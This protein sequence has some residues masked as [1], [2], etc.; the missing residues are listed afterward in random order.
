MKSKTT[1]RDPRRPLPLQ[2]RVKALIA[3][4]TASVALL[5]AGTA[6]AF[7]VE[8]YVPS[9]CFL[10]TS[11]GTMWFAHGAEINVVGS[12]GK[13]RRYRCNDG[14]WEPVKASTTPTRTSVG[15]LP[16]SGTYDVGT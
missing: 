7:P 14:K 15:T 11:L 12:D 8:G 2:R 5:A 9:K 10:K 3:L 4:G 1:T 6:H 13:Q 16:A